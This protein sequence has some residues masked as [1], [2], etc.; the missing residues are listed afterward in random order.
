MPE[1]ISQPQ[2]YDSSVK[3]EFF[4]FAMTKHAFSNRWLFCF[5]FKEAPQLTIDKQLTEY[6]G[7]QKDKKVPYVIVR[8]TVSP[9][10]TPLQS[11]MSPSVT[12]VLQVIKVK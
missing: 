11:I 12:G 1:R 4:R 9:I 5:I 10:G 7:A 8:G 3:S 6:V 2:K